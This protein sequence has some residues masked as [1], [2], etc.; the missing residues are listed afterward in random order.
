M[1]SRDSELL[2]LASGIPSNS[3]VASPG[4]L[5][6]AQAMGSKSSM[7]GS[8]PDEVLIQLG[9]TLNFRLG[10][11]WARCRPLT[12]ESRVLGFDSRKQWG[13]QP[14]VSCRLKVTLSEVS[15]MHA[16]HSLRS[17]ANSHRRGRASKNDASSM[18][19]SSRYAR[20]AHAH[21]QVLRR[22]VDCRIHLRL[23]R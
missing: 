16:I 10:Y 8:G 23:S 1:C 4:L 22:S 17:Q 18:G 13:K 7:V 5:S 11:R 19:S 9:S 21:L 6:H 2:Q 12:S 20:A 15:K 14:K 3:T